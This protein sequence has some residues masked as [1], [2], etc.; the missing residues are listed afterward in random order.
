MEYKVES[1]ELFVDFVNPAYTSQRCSYC[2]FTHE[3]N[4][5]DKHFKCQDCGYEVNADYNA[6]KNIAVRYCGYI[7]RGQ[8]SRGGWATSQL[9][10]KSGTLN[11][12]GEYSPPT[13]SG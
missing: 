12:N 1:T 5:D 10:L 7:H 4:R 3:D 8:K 6:A 11:V 9:A 2:G 13:V